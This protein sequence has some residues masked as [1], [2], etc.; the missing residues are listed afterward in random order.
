MENSAWQPMDPMARVCLNE[1]PEWAC[2]VV[3][4]RGIDVHDVTQLARGDNAKCVLPDRIEQMIVAGACDQASGIC[5]L[6]KAAGFISVQGERF[7]YIYMGAEL[8]T[9]RRQSVVRVRR[10]RHM[11]DVRPDL[12]KH[13]IDIVILSGDVETRGCL[14]GQI[15]L[16]IAH[17]NDP[18]VGYLSE[19]PA[20]GRRRF[21]RNQQRLC[22]MAH[23][24]A[25]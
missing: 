16:A 18:G 12:R 24:L 9:F 6:K 20:D 13:A 11:H 22:V 19:F 4:L 3:P 21:G 14:I 15:R 5:E 17:C 2:C 8:Q 10:R 25:T 1:R 23:S 7:L